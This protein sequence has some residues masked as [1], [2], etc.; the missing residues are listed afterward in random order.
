MD[1]EDLTLLRIDFVFDQLV[2]NDNEFCRAK[3]QLK[4]CSEVFEEFSRHF[5]LLWRL[6]LELTGRIL[7]ASGGNIIVDGLLWA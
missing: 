1:G 2:V 3:N 4:K 6:D 7:D 5:M